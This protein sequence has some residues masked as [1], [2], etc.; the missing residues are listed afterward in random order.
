[1]EK[2]VL[3]A[4]IEKWEHKDNNKVEC[5][6]DSE[7]DRIDRAVNNETGRTKRQCANDLRTL[8][9]ILAK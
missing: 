4:L 1:M 9:Q 6:G 5:G 2:E 8:V 7:E 3:Y